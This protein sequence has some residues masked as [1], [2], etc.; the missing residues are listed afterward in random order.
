MLHFKGRALSYLST[1]R[2]SVLVG[3]LLV[4]IVG[5][6]LVMLLPAVG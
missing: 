6:I 4:I 2:Y 5:S 1:V 3:N